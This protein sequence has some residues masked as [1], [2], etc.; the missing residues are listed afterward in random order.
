MAGPRSSNNGISASASC[1]PDCQQDRVDM[2][3]DIDELFDRTIPRWLQIIILS[4]LIATIGSL[5][6][7]IGS[8]WTYAAETYATKEEV[9]ELKDDLKERMDM[10]FNRIIDAI[11]RQNNE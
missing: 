10:G 2:K 7:L 6:T 5:Y 4:L 9:K 1:P 3:K 8:E 11:E